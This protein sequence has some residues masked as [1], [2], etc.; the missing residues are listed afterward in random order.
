MFFDTKK[1]ESLAKGLEHFLESLRKRARSQDMGLEVQ[2]LRILRYR[3]SQGG[4]IHAFIGGF[5]RYPDVLRTPV[6]RVEHAI[7]VARGAFYDLGGH[8]YWPLFDRFERFPYDFC[9]I[10]TYLRYLR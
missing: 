10:T 4:A 1:K 2:R 8:L 3:G 6:E 5:G 9:H 7:D